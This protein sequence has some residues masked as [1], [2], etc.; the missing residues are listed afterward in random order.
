MTQNELSY[1][2]LLID[3]STPSEHRSN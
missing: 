1:T 2:A 3:E